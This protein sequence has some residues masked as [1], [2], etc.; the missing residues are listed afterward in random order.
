MST[1]EYI[2]WSPPYTHT[3]GGISVLHYLCHLLNEG[4]YSAYISSAGN[5]SWNEKGISRV[6]LDKKMKEGAIAVYPEIV[7]GNP[8]NSQRVVRWVLYLPGVIGGDKEYDPS[9]AVFCYDA[10]FC[11]AA[12]SDRLFAVD[13]D[14]CTEFIDKGNPR[15][16]NLLWVGKGRDMKRSVVQVPVKEITYGEPK[17]RAELVDWY[18]GAELLYSFDNM[19]RVINEARLCGCPVRLYPRQGEELKL[20]HSKYGIA[21]NDNEIQFAKDTVHMYR[22]YYLAW[23]ESLEKQF[24]DFVMLTQGDELWQR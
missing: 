15:K 8:Y 19:T 3:S 13:I 11:D 18:N 5:P 17:T 21:T 22:E 4:G 12:K 16:G 7:K 6:D 20:Q 14:E 9:E 23:R 10:R 1:R 2:I 24:L